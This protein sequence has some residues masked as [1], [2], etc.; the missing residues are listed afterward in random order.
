MRNSKKDPLNQAELDRIVEMAWE[1]LTPFDAIEMQFG[2]SEPEVIQIMREQMKRSSWLMWRKRVNGRSTKHQ[3]K[4][5]NKMS[6][7]RSQN[8]KG[9]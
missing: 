1:D 7:F 6:R 5:P 9:S 4:R 2:V 8:Q 3:A